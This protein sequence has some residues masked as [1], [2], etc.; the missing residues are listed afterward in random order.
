MVWLALETFGEIQQ[1]KTNFFLR[2][3]KFKISTLL[4]LCFLSQ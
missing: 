4:N 2:N 3:L 1:T